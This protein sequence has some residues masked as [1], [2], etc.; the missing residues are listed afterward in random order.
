M[1]VRRFRQGQG[2][3]QLNMFVEKAE[4]AFREVVEEEPEF[5]LGRMYLALSHFHEGKN[6]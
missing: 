2:F 6:G 5:L 4:Q 3:Y 1:V